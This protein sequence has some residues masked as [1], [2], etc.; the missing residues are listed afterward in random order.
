[1]RHQ[2][3]STI[4]AKIKKCENLMWL[5]MMCKVYNSFYVVVGMQIAHLLWKYV[6]VIF[7][8]AKHA[9]ILWSHNSIHKHVSIRNECTL[10]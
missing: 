8:K 3:T 2:Y 6:L 9:Y 5:A 1:M 10:W 7:S 4:I